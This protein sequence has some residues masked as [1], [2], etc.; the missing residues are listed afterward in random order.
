MK[1]NKKIIGIVCVALFAITALTSV[2]L[3]LNY[4][5]GSEPANRLI[6]DLHVWIGALYIL[7]ASI[8]MIKN[9]AF[10]KEEK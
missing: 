1:K 6:I 9:R 3:F 8:R 7:I 4:L 2:P 10:L 5:I